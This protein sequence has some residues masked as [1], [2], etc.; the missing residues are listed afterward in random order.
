MIQAG[1]RSNA[2]LRFVILVA[3][4]AAASVGAHEAAERLQQPSTSSA[5]AASQALGPG[6]SLV[7]RVSHVV[8]GDT[9]MI[10]AHERDVRVRL[11]GIDCP[12]SGQPLSQEALRF[13]RQF[14]FDQVVHL[15][16]VD[17]DR[18]GRLVARV[19][20]GGKDV[21]YE[22]L[23]AGLA[24]HYTT[25]SSDK[26]LA[27]AEKEARTARRG[28]WVDRDPTPPW[29]ARRRPSAAQESTP[30]ADDADGPFRG[31][32]RSRVYHTNSCRNARCRN[33]T[34]SFNTAKE[35]EAAGY[36]P[37]GDCMAPVRLRGSW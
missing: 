12:E 35:A 10:D 30:V 37:A 29:V 34:S 25:Y 21:S 1:R 16:I 14:A 6:S 23:R 32:T 27:E 17:V 15:K 4:L 18:Y 24:W 19:T 28:I 7:A 11:E 22:L 2:R 3:S 13:T 20:S 9:L 26:A 33:C 36:R 5:A 8:D 31:N